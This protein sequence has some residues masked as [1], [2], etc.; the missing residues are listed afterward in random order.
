MTSA[1]LNTSYQAYASSS[2]GTRNRTAGRARDGAEDGTAD[3]TADGTEA[4]AGATGGVRV[5]RAALQMMEEY[6]PIDC[7]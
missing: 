6:A 4:T 5:M 2:T 1:F 7:P 3:G